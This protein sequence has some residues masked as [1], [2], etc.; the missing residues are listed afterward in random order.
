MIKELLACPI[1]ILVCF[2]AENYKIKPN[3]LKKYFILSQDL[4]C[5]VKLLII[6][7]PSITLPPLFPYFI[8]IILCKLSKVQE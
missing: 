7:I 6:L 1:K 4:V 2:I 8:V 3:F 5:A